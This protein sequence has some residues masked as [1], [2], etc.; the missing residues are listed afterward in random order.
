MTIY[1]LSNAFY[2]VNMFNT[3]WKKIARSLTLTD[4][5]T[6]D[7]KSW[8]NIKHSYIIINVLN[9]ILYKIDSYLKLSVIT[10]ITR[11]KLID[12]EA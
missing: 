9:F 10:L 3:L 7:A 11:E 1:I 4:C 12:K 2:F 6:W 8:H 5:I